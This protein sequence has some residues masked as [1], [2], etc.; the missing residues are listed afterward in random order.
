[1]EGGFT[2]ESE[3]NLRSYLLENYSTSVR[4]D[5]TTVVN[6]SFN[7]VSINFVVSSLIFDLTKKLS[8]VWFTLSPFLH[9]PPRERHF[10]LQKPYSD[11]NK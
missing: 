11:A 3:T 4:P 2:V 6:M 10:G 1:M 8:K 7:L 9:F 5:V